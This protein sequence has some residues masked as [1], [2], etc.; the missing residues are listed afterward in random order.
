MWVAACL[1]PQRE[2]LALHCLKLGGFPTYLPRIRKRRI[3]R[4]RK[5]T[6]TPALFPG[7]L[8]VAIELQW[9]AA[10]WAPGVAGLIMDGIAPAR[11]PDQVI[12]EIRRRERRGLIDLP[13][14]LRPGDRVRIEHGPFAGLDGMYDGQAPQERIFILLALM[15]SCRVAVPAGDVARSR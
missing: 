15:G 9:H 13:A 8:F 14:W 4:G 3:I 12:D 2:T 7:Y 5:V 6:V 10:R 1:L 11:V